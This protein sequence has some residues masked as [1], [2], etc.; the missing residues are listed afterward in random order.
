MTLR[1]K[2]SWI[3]AR[4]RE[5]L[6]DLLRWP[7]YLNYLRLKW[8]RPASCW[9]AGDLW[10]NL[11][12]GKAYVEGFINVDVNL[13]HRRDMWL[14]LR[15]PLPFRDGEAAGIFTS[16]VL[17]H[18][19]LCEVQHILNECHRILQVGGALRV[20]VPS[21]ALAIEAYQRHDL[22]FFHGEGR[23]TGRRFVDHMLDKSNHRLM[24][25]CSMMEELLLDARFGEVYQAAYRQSIFPGGERLAAL[26]DRPDISLYVEARKKQVMTS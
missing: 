13:Y 10:I 5:Y 23:S 9:Q 1:P 8:V 14:D 20:S 17:E 2:R 22:E 15:N 3:S 7:A 4:Q 19:N 6:Y 25:D 24:F 26:D 11:G 21:L 18:F 16:H 12:S